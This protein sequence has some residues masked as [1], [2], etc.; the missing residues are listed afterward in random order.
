MSKNIDATITTKDAMIHA[1]YDEKAGEEYAKQYHQDSLS[2]LIS[3]LAFRAGCAHK[4]KQ[5][6]G[7]G[8]P[9]GYIAWHPQHGYCYDSFAYN[10]DNGCFD[11]M[12]SD[13]QIKPVRLVKVGV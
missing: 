7:D 4:E 1:D 12:A 2:L 10:A 6:L 11:G 13:W 9:Q 5:L 3:C 8:R